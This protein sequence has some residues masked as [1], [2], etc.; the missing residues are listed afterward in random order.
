MGNP[1]EPRGTPGDPRGPQ[2]SGDPGC[3]RAGGL[4]GSP[5]DPREPQGPQ[6]TPGDP[7]GPHIP[8][9]P[10]GSGKAKSNQDDDTL[11]P[12][13]LRETLNNMWPG[14]KFWCALPCAGEKIPNLEP[15]GAHGP[16]KM[17]PPT[18]QTPLGGG[19]GAPGWWAGWRKMLRARSRARATFFA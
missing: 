13:E 10:R 7:T 17:L 8:V 1:G 3:P 15:H 12:T 9:S 4:Q 14:L 18:A 16:P 2:R 5:G 11:S 6:G 19:P